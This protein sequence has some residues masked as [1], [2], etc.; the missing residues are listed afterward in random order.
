MA[1]ETFLLVLFASDVVNTFE[2]QLSYLDP[3]KTLDI[4]IIVPI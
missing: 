4:R 1:T 3:V 2:I